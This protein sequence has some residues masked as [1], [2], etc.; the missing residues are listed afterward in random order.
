MKRCTELRGSVRQ[1]GA[2]AVEFALVSIVFLSLLFGAI[3]FGRVLFYWNTTAE[4]ARLGTRIAVVCNK[5][6]A[7]I[8]AKM[9]A[10][11]PVLA[12]ADIAIEYVPGDCTV[13]TCESVTL[14]INA[15]TIQTFIPFNAL[16]LSLPP[17]T[18][19]LTR[20]SMQSNFN[21]MANPVCQ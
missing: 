6:A 13:D 7:A 3:E 14:T 9:R 8:K 21:A 11:F 2:A 4:A 19:T 15:K 12:D 18:T 5:D 17:F 20:E 10:L 1:R 16:N